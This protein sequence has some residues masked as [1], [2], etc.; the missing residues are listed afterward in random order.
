MTKP[1]GTIA[2]HTVVMILDPVLDA[3]RT[4]SMVRLVYQSGGSGSCPACTHCVL[5]LP[6]DQ[7]SIL[8]LG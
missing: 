2:R 4:V 6:T 5:N 1:E 8:V 7:Y 3:V